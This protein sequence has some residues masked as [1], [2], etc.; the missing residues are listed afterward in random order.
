MPD[1]TLDRI[2]NDIRA[3][4]VRPGDLLLVHSSL[5]SIGHVGGG[6]E[7]VAKALVEVVAP[8]GTVFV[9]T[10]NFGQHPWDPKTTPSVVGAVTEAFRHLAG[11]QRSLQC[12][13]A[14]SAIG[15]RAAD[16]LAD[17]E[18]THP[19][20]VDSPI[21]KLW[22]LNAWVLLLGCGH[23]SSSMIHVAEE[24]EN[25]PYLN[26]TRIQYIIAGDQKFDVEVRRPGRSNGF[27]KIDGPLRAKN[28]II[29]SKVGQAD[30]MLMRAGDIVETAREMLRM[31]LTALLCDDP[32]C[33]SCMES[34]QLISEAKR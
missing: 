33:E 19:F 10:F 16:I 12:T 29:G 20:A 6:A 28:A 31:D 27:Y 14:V 9:P 5:K 15:P 8:R 3:L 24:A 25:V 18:H 23:N 34:R 21:G 32:A 2:V 26:R 13:H 17:H 22:K 4:G 30:C 1:I 7:T 11:A